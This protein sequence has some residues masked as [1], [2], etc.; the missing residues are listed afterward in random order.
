MAE[1]SKADLAVAHFTNRK[2][3]TIVTRTWDAFLQVSKEWETLSADEL[4]AIGF[5]LLMNITVLPLEDMARDRNEMREEIARE[6]YSLVMK[7]SERVN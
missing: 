1:P 5:N 6:L 3:T 4:V 7:G 2:V